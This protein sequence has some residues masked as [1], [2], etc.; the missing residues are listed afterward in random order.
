M[1][2][3][4]EDLF[5]GSELDIDKVSEMIQSE[6]GRTKEILE[7]ISHEM[8]KEVELKDKLE[9]LKEEYHERKKELYREYWMEYLD[10]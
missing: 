3:T 5:H 6:P 1:E 7:F 10:D 9:D 8:R 2:L 4:R